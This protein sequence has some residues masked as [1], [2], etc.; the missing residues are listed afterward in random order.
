MAYLL[1]TISLEA[2]APHVYPRLYYLNSLLE[3]EEEEE[4]EEDSD[5]DDEANG[6]KKEVNLSGEQDLYGSYWLPPITRLSSYVLSY[7]SC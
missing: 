3:S 5:S 1:S 6:K 7:A 4:S 2:L